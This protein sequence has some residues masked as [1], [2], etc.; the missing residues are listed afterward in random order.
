MAATLIITG[1]I[2]NMSELVQV[3]ET[4]KL[5]ISIPEDRFIKKGK[6]ITVW[7]NITLWA[8]M[9]VQAEKYLGNGSVVEVNCRIDYNKSGNNYYT[10]FNATNI[11][12]HAN[13]GEQRK[14][15]AA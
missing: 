14:A 7:H 3:G 2:R 4:H 5:D 10:N 1:T 9:A 11:K 12:Y 8:E 6:T 13:F 15:P